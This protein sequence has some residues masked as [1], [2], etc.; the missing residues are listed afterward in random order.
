MIRVN[1]NLFRIAAMCMSSDKT[2][3]YLQ[4][5]FVEPHER[6]GATL[7]ATDG[8]YLVSIHDDTAVCD[9]S[10]IIKL[11]PD[12]LRACKP[13]KSDLSYVTRML[14]IG[15]HDKRAFVVLESGEPP[16][17]EVA[18]SPDCFV[19]G[20]FPAWRN[21]V[22]SSQTAPD[23]KETAPAFEQSVLGKMCD[24]AAALSSD[25]GLVVVTGATT[26]GPALVTFPHASHAFGLIMPFR[27]PDCFEARLPW[28]FAAKAPPLLTR[29]A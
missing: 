14:S 2:R 13:A 19:D 18:V 11:S 28:W 8:R 9:Q 22:T 25:K 3:Y 4:G 12:A 29:A 15:D 26:G 20:A 7:T 24:V 6:M 21:V 23:G 1:A 17:T 10:A 27:K 5:V 16:F